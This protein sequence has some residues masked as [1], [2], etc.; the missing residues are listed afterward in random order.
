MLRNALRALVEESNELIFKN[1]LTNEPKPPVS[2]II[3]FEQ[4]STIL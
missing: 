4:V 1:F 3:F 2:T